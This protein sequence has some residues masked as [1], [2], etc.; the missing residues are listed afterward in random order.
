[1][2][3]NGRINSLCRHDGPCLGF[4]MNLLISFVLAL[5]AL[6]MPFGSYDEGNPIVGA[7]RISSGELPYI[8]FWMQYP[9]GMAYITAQFM[10]LGL[11]AIVA[12]RTVDLVA[13]TILVYLFIA[14]V[15]FSGKKSLSLFSGL[16]GVSIPPFFRQS[17]RIQ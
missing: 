12:L 16:V 11:G 1:M 3:G 9:P 5:P 8:D 7:M 4:A 13:R 15:R 6:L 10:R 2:G 17:L 14:F